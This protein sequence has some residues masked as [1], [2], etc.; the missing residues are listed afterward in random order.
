VLLVGE[1]RKREGIKASS[2]FMQLQRHGLATAQLR[3]SVKQTIPPL[4]EVVK[5]HSAEK[6]TEAVD[7]LR[8]QGRITEIADG[9]E[10]AKLSRM[11]GCTRR[12]TERLYRNGRSNS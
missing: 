5:N 1:G 4:R 8:S 9:R 10:R 12:M 6:I 7:G 3:E 2:P 11:P